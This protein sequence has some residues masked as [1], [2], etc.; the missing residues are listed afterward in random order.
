MLSAARS[1]SDMQRTLLENQSPSTHLAHGVAR[2]P[3]SRSV[4]APATF[5]GNR[6]GE[7]SHVPYGN[8]PVYVDDILQVSERSPNDSRSVGDKENISP[9]QNSDIRNPP[10]LPNPLTDFPVLGPMT[11]LEDR[12]EGIWDLMIHTQPRRA[13]G[14][15]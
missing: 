8:F 3:P 14:E 1:E 4:A 7:W 2:F 9:R 5:R 12:G 11:S 15:G 6:E 10:R 13:G